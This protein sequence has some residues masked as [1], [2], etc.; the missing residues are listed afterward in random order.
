MRGFCSLE[1]VFISDLRLFWTLLACVLTCQT[2][3]CSHCFCFGQLELYQYLVVVVVERQ[4]LLL[5]LVEDF[6]VVKLILEA[7]LSGND[8]AAFIRAHLDL[9]T[10]P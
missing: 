3:P 4:V 9:S 10:S 5:L 8:V 1:S 2:P 6:R 7:V